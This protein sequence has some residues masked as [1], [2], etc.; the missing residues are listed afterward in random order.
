VPARHL[1]ELPDGF[2]PLIVAGRGLAV[3]GW[4]DYQGGSILRY[5]ELFASV[6]GYANG[7]RSVT[8]TV[9]HMWVDSE[10]SM[11]G[12]R[13][14]WGYPKELAEFDLR[15]A[16]SGTGVARVGAVELARGAY[17]ALLRVPVRL[18]AKTGTVQ[19]LGGVLTP[20]RMRT[21][22]TPSFGVGSLNPGAGSPLEFLRHGTRLVSIGMQDFEFAFGV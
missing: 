17:R 20:V 21:A 16:P 2:K 12:G 6:A 8:A 4:V 1:P 15:I 22:F 3:A 5:G 13:E 9:T 19:P 10:A 18:K 14:L 11:R 7:R